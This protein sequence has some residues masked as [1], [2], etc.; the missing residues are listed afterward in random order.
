MNTPEPP[1]DVIAGIADHLDLTLDEAYVLLTDSERALAIAR[2]IHNIF[3]LSDDY[4]ADGPDGLQIFL[5]GILS[6][7]E[8]MWYDGVIDA[9]E[10]SEDDDCH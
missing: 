5:K 1:A 8:A 9:D 7:R 10:P 6:E 4:D 3:A 2:A